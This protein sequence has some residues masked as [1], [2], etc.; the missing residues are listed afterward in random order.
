MNHQMINQ[1]KEVLNSNGMTRIARIQLL[2]SLLN[3][4]IN[5]AASA[6]VPEFVLPFLTPE[7]FPISSTKFKKQL[8]GAMPEM[9]SVEGKRRKATRTIVS[10]RDMLTITSVGN[11]SASIYHLTE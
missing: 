9:K 1:L 3:E 8:M 2:T 6:E 10:L 5:H 7:N 4:E 11:G